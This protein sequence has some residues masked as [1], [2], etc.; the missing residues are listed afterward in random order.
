[1]AEHPG[2]DLHRLLDGRLDAARAAEVEAHVA[3]CATCRR[4]V[5]AV[6][7]VKAALRGHLPELPVPAHVA[8]RVRAATSGA[9]AGRAFPLR[10]ALA[11]AAVLALAAVSLYQLTRTRDGAPDIVQAVG[12]DFIEY[13]S[14]DLRLR[15]PTSVAAEV[16]AFFRDEGVPFVSPVFQF[17]VMDFRLTGGTVRGEERPR[18]VVTY[19]G[20]GGDR[21]ICE[22]YEGTTDALPDATEVREIDGIRFFIYR[23]RDLTLVFWQDGDLVCVLVMDGDPERAVVFAHAKATGA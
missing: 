22:M 13:R 14:G 19:E 6:R 2:D 5:E 1:M 9:G 16:E 4:E 7:Q 23:L 18:A 17:D 8:A 21:M 20:V 15:H 11:A 10:R 3:A 12:T